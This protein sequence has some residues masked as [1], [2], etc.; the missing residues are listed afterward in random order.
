MQESEIARPRGRP[1]NAENRRQEMK[2]KMKMMNHTDTQMKKIIDTQMTVKEV[3]TARERAFEN[4]TLRQPSRFERV[5]I[6]TTTPDEMN[7]KAALAVH[8]ADS[9]PG[10]RRGRGR[11]RKKRGRGGRERRG[12]GRGRRGRGQAVSE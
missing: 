3:S 11:G 4:S 6:E 10:R 12:R 2:M 9:A 5:L 7:T 8:R 1:Q